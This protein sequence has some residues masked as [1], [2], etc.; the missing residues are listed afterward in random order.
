MRIKTIRLKNG[1]KRFKDFTIN[2]GDTPAKIIALVGPN[3]SG[4]SSVFDG[5]LYLQSK[6]SHIGESAMTAWQYH[7]MDANPG[8]DSTWQDNVSIIFDSGSFE[9]IFRKKQENGTGKTIFSFR[10]PY[11][12]S[13]QLKVNTLTKIGDIKENNIGAGATV[14]LDDKVTD[15]YQRL[16]SLIDRIYKA[17]GS[18]L[19]YEQVKEQVLGRLNTSLGKVLDIVISDHGDILDGKG[20]L[21][22]KKLNQETEFEFNVLSSGEKEVVDILIDLFIKKEEFQETIYLIDEPELHINT[23]IQRKLLNEIVSIIPNTCQIWIA[24]H[25]IGFLN[26]LKQDHHTD[27][28]VIWFTPDLVTKASEVVP[29]IKSRKNWKVV[30]ET[31]LEDLTGLISPEVIVYCEG[32]K[33]LGR[34]GE[35]LGL[36]AEVYN[37]I[38]ELEF[39]NTLFVSSG[40]STEPDKYSEV[41]IKVLSKAFDSVTLLLLKDKDIRG[42]GSVTTNLEREAWILEN[43]SNRRML[44]RKEIENYLFDLDIVKKLNPDIDEVEYRNMISDINEGNIKDCGIQ[45]KKLCGYEQKSEREFKLD[46]AAQISSDTQVY[47]ELRSLIFA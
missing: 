19:T 38:F 18:V 40:G 15:N 9:S 4:K 7:S 14:H 1:Y 47:K 36:D 23:N 27:S 44:I 32:R 5:M 26:A 29:M 33:D 31:A 6:Y 10:S 24:T 20:T 41:A 12:Y 17:P 11:R 8:F 21:Y 25:S 42:D 39:P 46:L 35:E 37:T 28:A 45:L 30:F 2:L 34:N 13:S 22:F 43:P 3:G 16:Y